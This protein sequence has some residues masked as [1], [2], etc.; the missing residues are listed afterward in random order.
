MSLSLL[1][2]HDSMMPALSKLMF[3]A[4]LPQLAAT[5]SQALKQMLYELQQAVDAYAAHDYPHAHEQSASVIDDDDALYPERFTGP[6]SHA[7]VALLVR[8]LPYLSSSAYRAPFIVPSEF[9]GNDTARFTAPTL[10]T[11]LE[12]STEAASSIASFASLPEDSMQGSLQM[13]DSSYV[14]L[15][16]GT[17]P[18]VAGNNRGPIP[19]KVKL[20]PEM[21]VRATASLTT[22]PSPSLTVPH[23]VSHHLPR[24]I[25]QAETSRVRQ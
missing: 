3:Q 17:N 8:R 20:T 16:A 9:P 15:V 19:Q 4:F 10:M 11:T 14:E 25:S 13:S 2:K 18:F 22:S 21:E 24:R 1:L 6:L 12:G 23:C 5:S 7:E